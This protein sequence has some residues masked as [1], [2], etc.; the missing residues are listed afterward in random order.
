MNFASENVYTDYFTRNFVGMQDHG[1][2][3]IQ[4]ICAYCSREQE[5][6]ERDSRMI[7]LSIA[8]E[9]YQKSVKR[10]QDYIEQMER[11]MRHYRVY[12]C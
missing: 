9:S 7:A 2:E 10:S 3:Q 6:I 8:V 1:V 4:M 12:D 11:Q 5:S